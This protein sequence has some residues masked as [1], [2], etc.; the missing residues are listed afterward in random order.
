VR[1]G[2]LAVL[3]LAVP[4]FAQ[5]LE[6]TI[7]VNVV[8]VPVY[9]ERFGKPVTGL[10]RDDFELFV[11]GKPHPIEYFDVLS[12]D[13][14]AGVPQTASA[15]VDL[16]RRRL[17]VLLF[18]V[19]APPHALDR[20]RKA[21][22]NYVAAGGPGDTFAVA[23]VSWPGVLFIVP[24]T[25]D[26]V[27]VHRA[28]ATLRPSAARDPF[29]VAMLDVERTWGDPGIIGGVRGDGHPRGF[30]PPA[31]A[32]L[33]VGAPIDMDGGQYDFSSRGLI[34]NL[35]DLA[36][37]LAAL[38]GLKEVVLLS[39]GHGDPAAG[40]TWAGVQATMIRMHERFRAA[41][42]VLNAVDISTRRAPGG[43][44]VV[45]STPLRDVAPALTTSSFLWPLALDTGGIATSSFRELQ[46]RQNVGYL[47]GFRA[48]ESPSRRNSITVRVKDLPLLTDVRYRRAY[49]LERATRDEGLFLA[50]TILNDIP[51][52]GVTLDLAVDGKWV[53]ATIPGIELLSYASS[54][55][56]LNLDVY[57]YIF[58]GQQRPVAWNR[59]QIAVDLEKGRE[60]LTS[61]PY[62]MRQEFVLDP[63]R[64]VA[65]AL[66]RI[67]GTDHVGFERTELEVAK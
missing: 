58:D 36:D 11:N 57:F 62:T 29:R 42:V 25:S 35:T 9:V 8:D 24:F 40:Y 17:I 1:V 50:D 22:A 47:I 15:P 48:P 32:G 63:G 5:R 19:A 46:K 59:M 14:A 34:D 12:E 49:T 61:N 65:K 33:Y 51:Q 66:V 38:E 26:R 27:A 20:V 64:Y 18:D 30:E 16:K 56:R 45:R 21:A 43:A 37:R 31:I 28:I 44:A 53:A 13:A 2:I 10:A 39:E 41:G 7:T 52:N 54:G 3:L 60:F 67:A 4:L 23:T 55:H 6:D